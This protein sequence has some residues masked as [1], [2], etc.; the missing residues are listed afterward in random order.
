MSITYSMRCEGDVLYVTAS[1]EDD[2]ASEVEAYGMSI[3]Q[4]AVETHAVRVLC[5]ERT[6]RYRLDTIENF[7]SASKMAEVIPRGRQVAIV[8]APE[9]IRDAKFWET[10]AVNRG[11]PVCVF[12]QLES[13]K[14][15]LNI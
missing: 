5:D 1:G 4:K 13:A 15:W 9:S 7:V 3:L 2:N 6:L 14:A 11:A 12:T 10:V 8:C